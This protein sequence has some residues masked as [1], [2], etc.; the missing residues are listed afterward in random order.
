MFQVCPGCEQWITDFD[1][2]VEHSLIRCPECGTEQG[3][4]FRPLRVLFGASGSGKSTVA[5]EL[6]GRP[7]GILVLDQ[8][9][10][11][12][13]EFDNAADGYSRF[14][15]TWLRLAANIHQGGSETLLVGSGIPVQFETRPGRAW[16]PAAHYAALVCSASALRDRLRARPSWR[17][18]SDEETVDRMVEYNEWLL[19]SG[20]ESSPPITLIDTTNDPVGVTAEAVAAWLAGPS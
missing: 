18:S 6:I 5:R 15:D 14:R 3:F 12:S 7:T 11:W 17:H 16:F 8:D 19:S 10:L 20:P 9:I 1:T 13:Q 2:D 4:R